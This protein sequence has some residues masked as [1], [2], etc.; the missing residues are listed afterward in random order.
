MKS[1]KVYISGPISGRDAGE[2]LSTFMKEEK[3]LQE[4][5]YRTINP[6][7]M[8]LCVWL[9]LHGHYRLCLLIELCWMAYRADIISMLPDWQSSC[10]ART[11]YAL[12]NALGINLMLTE[13]PQ[14]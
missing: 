14:E 9:A 11:E 3:R 13:S 6:L 2:V 4:L 12:A 10:G 8:R 7:R 5:G 1:K